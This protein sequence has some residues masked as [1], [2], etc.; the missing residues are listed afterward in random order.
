MN[1]ITSE[2]AK[3]LRAAYF[4]ENWT[5]SYFKQHLDGVTW[6]QATKQVDSL[7]TIAILVYHTGYY[8]TGVSRVL[9]NKPLDIK[10]EYSFNIPLIDSEE[11]WQDLLKKTYESAENFAKLIENLPD[12]KLTETFVSEKYGTYYRNLHGIIEHLHYHLGQI[13]LI[14]KLLSSSDREEK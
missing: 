9:Q 5:G 3:L 14:K 4:G 8:I 10:D 6:E 2:I 11:A 12:S 13:V 1:T 7:N